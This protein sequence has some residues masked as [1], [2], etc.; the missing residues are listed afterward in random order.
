MAIDTINSIKSQMDINSNRNVFH[1]GVI[2]DVNNPNIALVSDFSEKGAAKK[3]TLLTAIYLEFY[4]LCLFSLHS[5]FI[6]PWKDSTTHLK[7]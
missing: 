2:S 3:S 6:A 5:G 4:I 1:T 7:K